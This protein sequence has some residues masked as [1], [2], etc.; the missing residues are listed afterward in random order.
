M[1]ILSTPCWTPPPYHQIRSNARDL[2]SRLGLSSYEELHSLSIKQP[3]AYWRAIN[4]FCGVAWETPYK[5]FLDLSKGQEF[6]RW[7]VGGRLNWVETVLKWADDP[8]RRN[9]PAIIAEHETGDP[10]VISFIQLRD[11]VESFAAGLKKQG[12]GRGDRVGLLMDVGIEAY[13]S[14][15]AAVYLGAIVVP[16]FS[17][18]GADAIVSRLGACD[19]KMLLA[20]TGFMRR[21]RL[22]DVTALVQQAATLLPSLQTIVWKPLNRNS[23]FPKGV[24]WH[25]VST[26]PALGQ[27]HQ[28]MDPNDPFLVIYTSGTT[29]KPKG[30][31][32]THG[33]FPLRILSDAAIH[34]DI[35]AGDVF[36]WPADLG[37]IVGSIAPLASL[38]LG[39]TLV[40]YDG[41]PDFP[42]WSRMGA[43][44]DRHRVT[45]FGASP[46][47]IRSLAAHER[48]S[49][50]HETSSL[51]ILVTAGEA[52]DAEHFLWYQRAFAGDTPVINYTGGTEV[53]GAL[54]TSVTLRPIAPS[55]FNTAALG[56]DVDVV[57]AQ[58]RSLWDEVGELA[59]LQPF[60]GMPR[61]FW[62]D[63]ARYLESYWRT[64]PGMWIH[65]DL[66]LRDTQGFFYIRGRSDD[67]L[68][69][70][71]KRL[72]PAEVEEVVLELD[73][74]ADVA[75]IGMEDKLKGEKLVVFVTAHHGWSGES[76]DLKKLVTDQVILKLGKPFRPG[77]VC[78]VRQ[79]P[80]TRSAKV[81]RRVIRNL[82]NARDLGDLS[83][84]DNLDS[85]DEIRSAAAGLR[86]TA[87]F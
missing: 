62:Q 71:G 8:Q 64:V 17:G 6:P 70:A 54:L 41:A 35:S 29:G 24:N 19:A 67:T 81:M 56:V 65:G 30:P 86:Q 68:K 23:P 60:I 28:A 43:L 45:H 47:L 5:D 31:V 63:D 49:L 38:A 40:T 75:A 79:L 61:S 73:P 13:V 72:G 20:S 87:E 83:S 12:L 36:C 50:R 32:H 14:Y 4:D 69:I 1:T 55:S 25:E 10:E 74:I 21:Q 7:F 39:A 26:A 84:I 3:A 85:L 46:T 15:L 66:A 80:K 22:V 34:L 9:V 11:Q 82:C 53:G 76:D 44:I 2:A 37:W 57:D 77:E 48:E 16:L 42:D 27:R 51:K 18:F 33:S 52:I 78:I 59:L 58:G